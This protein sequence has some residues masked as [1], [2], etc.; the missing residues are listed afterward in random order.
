MSAVFHLFAIFVKVV[1]PDDMSTCRTLF[2]KVLRDCS[3]TCVNRGDVASRRRR[4]DD[5]VD[6]RGITTMASRRRGL[7]RTPSTRPRRDGPDAVRN[8][9]N[10]KTS[11]NAELALVHGVDVRHVGQTKVE[12][13]RALRDRSIFF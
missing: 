5:H 10:S 9:S 13:R 2:S 3:S 12:Q 4:H 1:D 7:V 8:S 6:S 11:Q